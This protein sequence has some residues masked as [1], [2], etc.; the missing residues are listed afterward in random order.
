MPKTCNSFSDM[1]LRKGNLYW[2]DRLIYVSNYLILRSIG[3]EYPIPGPLRFLFLLYGTFLSNRLTD[4]D[5]PIPG[6]TKFTY[7]DFVRP[8]QG[9][10]NI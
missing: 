7:L 2:G 3:L 10:K 5:Q 4:A 1:V 9:T 8:N 6:T